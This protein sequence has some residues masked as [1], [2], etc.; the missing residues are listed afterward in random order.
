MEC[1]STILSQ[2]TPFVTPPSIQRMPWRG[3]LLAVAAATVASWTA[4]FLA[5][6]FLRLFLPG[7]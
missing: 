3:I 5:G 2:Y 4:G 1:A 7:R 6:L